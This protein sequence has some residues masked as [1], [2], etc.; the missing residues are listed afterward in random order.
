M[1]VSEKKDYDLL[2]YRKEHR[3]CKFCKYLVVSS[4]PGKFV[5]EVKLKSVN[6]NIPRWLCEG[7]EA[8]EV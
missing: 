5:C 8:R 6:A 2:E 3:R 4:I 7:Y 1:S